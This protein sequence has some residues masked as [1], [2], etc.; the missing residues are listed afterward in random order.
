M[1][2]P[3]AQPPIASYQDNN[4]PLLRGD[5]LLDRPR[6]LG[7]GWFA[8]LE[9]DVLGP[10]IKNRLQAPVAIKSPIVQQPG[11]LEF[12]PDNV[13][14]PTAGL[15]W[16][17][18]PRFELGYR[19][20]EGFGEFLLSYRLL[21]TEGHATMPGFD[22]GDVGFLKSR[23]DLHAVDFDYGSR[24]FSL[25]PHWDMKWRAGV[26][27]ANFYFDSVALGLF[28]EE[29]T[30]DHF[31]GAGPHVGLDLCRSL[32][33]DGMGLFV[34][35]EGASVVGQI[36]QNF[37]S[38]IGDEFLLGGA[39]LVHHTQAVPVLNVQAGLSWMP[40]HGRTRLAMGYEFERWWFVGEAG[41]SRAE[42]TTQGIFFRVEFGF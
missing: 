1:P 6:A 21:V 28:R 4:G 19:F 37:K 31:I 22:L 41:E 24:E 2:F 30:S 33:I 23:L 17:A 35:L 40:W 8:A 38:V 15:D 25:D 10:Q 18:A 9:V 36:S 39:T 3:L 16:T 42:L 34:R 12:L 27:L 14:L 20:A 26:R 13:H 29:G 7:P 5:P 11:I 32:Q